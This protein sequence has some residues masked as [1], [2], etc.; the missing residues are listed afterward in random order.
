METDLGQNDGSS[1]EQN[2]VK[3]FDLPTIFDDDRIVANQWNREWNLSS[4][5]SDVVGR[6]SHGGDLGPTGS[7]SGTPFKRIAYS[8]PVITDLIAPTTFKVGTNPTIT[9]KAKGN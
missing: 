8:L 9:I 6:A 3:D 5:S 2:I 7:N 1:G 4:S